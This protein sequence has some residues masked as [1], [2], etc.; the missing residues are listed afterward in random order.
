MK[1]RQIREGVSRLGAV[2]WNRRLFDSLITLPDGTSY[3]AYLIKGSEKTAPVDTADPT[4]AD[5]LMAQLAGVD[6]I[7]Y[8]VA[9]HAQQDHSG[10]IPDVLARYPNVQ[11]V[12]TPKRKGMLVDLLPDLKVEILEPVLCRGC[13]REDTFK[14]LDALAA[15]VAEKHHELEV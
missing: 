1:P 12:A 2:D 9:N 5:I 7:D 10:T 6:R 4:K 11:V 3:N 13:P 15:A 14:A 8:L